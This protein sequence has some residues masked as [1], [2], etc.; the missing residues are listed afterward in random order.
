MNNIKRPQELF[1]IYANHYETKF[2]D[3]SSY[4]DTFDVFC[5]LIE[6]K[7]AEVLELACGP[8]NI[9]NYILKK[10]PDFKL[11]GTDLAPKMLELAKKNNPTAVF[12]LMDCRAIDKL[13]DKYD[14]IL[15]GFG[16]PYISKDEAIQFIRNASVILNSGGIIYLSTMEDLYSKSGLRTSS[17]GKYRSYI[18][19]HE[20][21]YLTSSLTENGFEIMDM[22]RIDYP[23]QN[24]DITKDLVIIAKKS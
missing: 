8:G 21:D 7:N 3:L 19:Y 15:F 12:T 4:H 5:E 13:D 24:G 9:T 17:D 18:H 1:D 2:M 14:A 20:A 6:K 16:L 10:R 23:E 22:R 11:I